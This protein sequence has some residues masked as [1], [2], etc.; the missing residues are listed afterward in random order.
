[1][2]SINILTHEHA[3]A[4][5]L[6]IEKKTASLVGATIT[7]IVALAVNNIPRSRRYPEFWF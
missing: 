5:P 6:D 1:V 3:L 7:L 4:Q 2:N